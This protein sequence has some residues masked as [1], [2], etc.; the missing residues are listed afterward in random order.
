VF[1]ADEEVHALEHQA[2]PRVL[3]LVVALAV[4]AALR[5]P[6]RTPCLRFRVVA[7]EG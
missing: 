4:A 3:R 5:A 6:L 7:A 2:A 1:L